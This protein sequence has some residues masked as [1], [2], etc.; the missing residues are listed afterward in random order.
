MRRAAR[1]SLPRRIAR[2]TLALVR[3]A[4]APVAA[5]P[6]LSGGVA[7]VAL[8]FVFITGNAIY[9]QP[10]R[11]PK[12]MMATRAGPLDAAAPAAEVAVNDGTLMAVPLVLEVQNVLA[13]TGH[14]TAALDGKPGRATEAAIRAFQ[15]ENGLSVDGEP[16]PKL[17]SQIHRAMAEATSPSTRPEE[18]AEAEGERYAS[19]DAQMAAPGSANDGSPGSAAQ[20]APGPTAPPAGAQ[21][22]TVAGPDRDL[23]RRI[24]AGLADAQVAKLDADGIMGDKT[25]SAIRAFQ[26]LEGMD[27][28]GEP[29]PA[30]LERLVELGAAR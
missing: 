16:S 12:P 26:A 4:G 9:S 15:A 5:R 23:V 24:Q 3:L 19:V 20:S 25:R 2:G 13:R 27:V 18:V 21:P 10:G 29:S 14:Y 22:Q 7:G 8:L 30:I 6:V 1:P 28:T 17:L 11:H